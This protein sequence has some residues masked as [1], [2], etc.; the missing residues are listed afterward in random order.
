LAKPVSA[1]TGATAPVCAEFAASTASK[2]PSRG[3]VSNNLK[4]RSQWRAIAEEI[5]PRTGRHLG[6]FPQA[7]PT[8]R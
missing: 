3:V 7:P 6:N 1:H 8:G 4:P 5:E 2:A